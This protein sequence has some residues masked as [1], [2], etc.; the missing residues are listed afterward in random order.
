MDMVTGRIDLHVHSTCSDGTD[1]PTELVELAVE[2][3]L[4]AMAL[5]DHDCMDG[6]A[7][8]MEAAKGTG[9][10]IIPGVE[11]SCEYEGKEIHVVGLYVDPG[12][13][14][15]Q[16]KLQEFRDSRSHRNEIMVE[17]LRKEAGLVIDYDSLVA[18]NPDCVITRAN[19]ARYLVNHGQ[20]K[21]IEQVFA[22]YIGDDCPYFVPRAKVLPQEAI[23][24]IHMAGGVAV[25]AHPILYHMNM[26]R[27][28]NMVGILK[29]AGLDGIE[30][31]YSTYQLGDEANMKKLAK[32]YDLFVSGGSDYHGENK[33]YI[34]LGDGTRH[35]PIPAYLL[36]NIKERKNRY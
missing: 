22:K 2:T 30:A 6:V 20:V 19:I 11:I 16:M 5:T 28:E 29:D 34:K 3:G 25:L 9:L 27:M 33:T 12:P 15:L 32:Q 23:G 7:E 35:M 24:L 10:E 4:S 17:K 26:Q 8:A 36:E 1:T 13:S 18:E 31:V 14:V 21:S